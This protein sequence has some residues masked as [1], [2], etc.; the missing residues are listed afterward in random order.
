MDSE[1]QIYYLQNIR[2]RSILA[3]G[4]PRR[5]LSQFASVASSR[6]GSYARPAVS[7]S[8]INCSRSGK[9]VVQGSQRKKEKNK[10]P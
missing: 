9:Q 8:L 3:V 6:N 7:G 4:P 5:R 10:G 2:T 1:I